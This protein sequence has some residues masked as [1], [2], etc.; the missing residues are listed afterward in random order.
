MELV[1]LKLNNFKAGGFQRHL[2]YLEMSLQVKKYAINRKRGIFK[3][4]ETYEK[5]VKY[6]FL[7]VAGYLS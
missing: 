3:A 4:K 7:N 5:F 1:L 2:I 6:L